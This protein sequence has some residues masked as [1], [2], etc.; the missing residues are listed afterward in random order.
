MLSQLSLAAAYILETII[1][2]YNLIKYV[3][4]SSS[5][6]HPIKLISSR[7]LQITFL[8]YFKY[9]Y[10]CYLLTLRAGL[11]KWG[12]RAPSFRYHPRTYSFHPISYHTWFLAWGWKSCQGLI[13]IF[14]F[15]LNCFFWSWN[16]LPSQVKDGE[17]MSEQ[18]T[19]TGEA[20][21]EMNSNHMLKSILNLINLID[22]QCARS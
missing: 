8:S 9:F 12:S 6:C 21:Y 7:N 13:V 18:K 5:V 2:V 19:Y 11:Q 1:T 16:A 14:F 22:N 20:L 3:P 15:S 10:C 4:L 17:K